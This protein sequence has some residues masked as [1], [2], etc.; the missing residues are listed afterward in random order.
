[1][2]ASWIAALEDAE[3]FATKGHGAHSSMRVLP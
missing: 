1:M 3:N 2:A